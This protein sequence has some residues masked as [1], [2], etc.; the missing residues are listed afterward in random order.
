MTTEI[1]KKK[2]ISIIGRRPTLPEPLDLPV[3]LPKT[4]QLA[5]VVQIE[6]VAQLTSGSVK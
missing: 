3:V 1:K 5:R 2:I 4:G 6:R